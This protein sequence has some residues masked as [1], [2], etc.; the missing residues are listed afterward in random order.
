VGFLAPDTLDRNIDLPDFLERFHHLRKRHLSTVLYGLPSHPFAPVLIAQLQ[1]LIQGEKDPTYMLDSSIC[2]RSPSGLAA[3]GSLPRPG[4]HRSAAQL[5]PLDALVSLLGSVAWLSPS[6]RDSPIFSHPLA[7]KLTCTLQQDG[8]LPED[9]IKQ[10]EIAL[11]NVHGN[12]QAA[13]MQIRY[14]V[15][16][17]IY[18]V[19][20]IDVEKRRQLLSTWLKGHEPCMTLI[21][22]AALAS[23]KLKL[24]PDA[25]ACADVISQESAF[26]WR[27]EC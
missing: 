27:V 4:T 8:T 1:L 22:V 18:L 23:S 25:M 19:D 14:M 17:T 13:N 9:P 6:L 20:S 12:L 7:P 3:D 16:L 5:S 2:L 15:K 10:F 11:N 24:E 21:Y 26:S